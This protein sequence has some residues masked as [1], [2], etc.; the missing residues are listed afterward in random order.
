[1][2]F[3]TD[4]LTVTKV[5]GG[6]I[7]LIANAVTSA[8]SITSVA[9]QNLTLG[10]GTGGTALTLTNSTLAATFAGAVSISG[11]TAV[12]GAVVAAHTGSNQNL[13]IR[14]ALALGGG[15]SAIAIQAA[16]DGAAA[17][18]PLEIHGSTLTLNAHGGATTVADGLVVSATTA[19]SST[20]TGALVV[21]GGAGF[22]GQLWAGGAYSTTN[23][24]ALN[25]IASISG[26][27][28][29]DPDG[30]AARNFTIT[31]GYTNAG[32]FEVLYGTSAGAAP[33]TVALSFTQSTATW[34]TAR[35]FTITNATASSSTTTGALVVS[36]GVGIAGSLYASIVN[37]T[38]GIS[39]ASLTL[40]GSGAIIDLSAS[41]TGS[42]LYIAID[43]TANGG[44][45]RWRIG[46]SGGIGGF[47]SCDIYNQ[48][49]NVTAL[50]CSVTATTVPL[51]TASTSTTTGS[52]INAGG[53]GNAGAGYFGGGI[54]VTDGIS[55]VGTRLISSLTGGGTFTIRTTDTASLV[56]A[57][58]STDCFTI[59]GA[60]GAMTA[61]FPLTV[62]ASTESTSTTTG[63]LQTLGGLG[64]A[65]N[66]NIGG[67]FTSTTLVDSVFT[68]VVASTA[69]KYLRLGTTG[70][71]FYLG[72]E[73]AATGFFTG[74]GAYNTV[75]YSPSN[76]VYIRTP[77]ISTNGNL[78][79]SG[80]NVGV[81]G[82]ASSAYGLYLTS[83]AL[84]G[85]GQ[86]GAY[87]EPTFTSAATSYAISLGARFKTAA[88]LTTGSGYTIV[89][90]TPSIGG[91]N[92][93]TTLTGFRVENHGATGVTHAYGIDIA[94]QSGAAT[95]NVGL[96]NSG[97]TQLNGGLAFGVTSIATAA[98]TTTLTSASTSIQIFTGATT[99]TVQLPTA[100]A[101]G[102]GVAIVY[103]IKNRSSGNVTVQRAGSDT[104]EGS[105]TAVLS[106][107]L[108]QS[109]TLVS[110]GVSEWEIV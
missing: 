90:D 105:T 48:T 30:G 41:A 47:G 85:T 53:F 32:I 4:T 75:L 72:I 108:N 17:Y 40:A 25:L 100:A 3:A 45:K 27:S 82:A 11:A 93:I 89:A 107:G 36:G 62:S 110:N 16:T 78:T 64:V 7:S 65:K 28:L 51:T 52:L 14:P 29:Q 96:R 15:A 46:H 59:N 77:N 6:G 26:I 33:D 20:T 56:L 94:A 50:T 63:S 73:S 18:A 69:Q 1:M 38:A 98:G 19:S 61:A 43:Q 83:T 79:V 87:A 97:T 13:Y 31:N 102:A 22:A 21:S 91:S 86:I 67:T 109:Y 49:D 58:Q 42:P 80:G 60:N 99:Q 2:T 76:D 106:G 66:V 101:I 104:I 9:G 54:N 23:A 74:A 70:G 24:L 37:V 55:L 8:N 68:N 34:A 84:S 92:A 35:V 12:A 81:G 10:L 39:G 88:S 95:T 44:G 57:V 103:V 5:V 71:D